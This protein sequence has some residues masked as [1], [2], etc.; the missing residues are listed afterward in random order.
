MPR[1]PE[2]SCR[3]LKL[4]VAGVAFITLLVGC[5]EQQPDPHANT[6]AIPVNDPAY[7]GSAVCSDCHAAEYAAWSDSHH[8]LAMQIATRETVLGNFEDTTYESHGVTSAFSSDGEQF[9]VRTDG[10]D[11]ELKDYT[12]THTFGI[13]PLQQYLVE[14]P[15]GHY[16]MLPLAWDTRLREEGGQRWFHLYPGEDIDY[17]D[18]LHWTGR[19]QNWNYMCAECHSTNLRK[20]YDVAT[21]S[22]QTTWS[23]I[24]VSCEACHGPASNHIKWTQDQDLSYKHSGL[25]V[26][27]GREMNWVFSN[28]LDTATRETS[29]AETSEIETCARCHSRRRTIDEDYDHGEILMQSHVPALLTDTLYFPDGQIKDEVYVYGSF[30][31]SLMYHAGV[32]CSDCHEPHSLTLR[33]P[34]NELCGQCHKADA[35]DTP[36]HHY[37]SFESEGSQCVSCHM[38]QRTYMV[39]DPR[40]DH[41]IRI[42]RP[43]LTVKLSLPNACNACHTDKSPKWAADAIAERAPAGYKPGDHFGETL[44]ADRQGIRGADRELARLAADGSTPAIVHATALQRLGA[45]DSVAAYEAIRAGLRDDH[46][47]VRQAALSALSTYEADVRLLLA[48][49]L[50]E[51]PVF[52][53]RIAAIELLADVPREQ[54]N[55]E[56]LERFDSVA[57]EYVASNLAN[58]ERPESHLN[59]GLFYVRQ[60]QFE[61]AL[62]EYEIALRLEPDFIPALVNIADLMRATGRDSE[63]GA[64][65]ERAMSVDP[66]NANIQQAKG[67]WLVRQ[68]RTAEALDYLRRSAELDP[69]QPYFAYLYAVALNSSGAP[70]SAIKVLEDAYR[71]HPGHRQILV[72]LTTIYRDQGNLSAAIHYAE[73]LVA[74][75]PSE[76]NAQR[77]LAELQTVSSE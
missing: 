25:P 8:D 64:Y 16:Q 31:Q 17:A 34:G 38:P 5:S 77:L 47:L 24:D 21:D 76:P 10:P 13:Q 1:I 7:V 28:Y 19:N 49:P 66:E 4:T 54:M 58:A 23:E 35:F 63:G 11:G 30:T 68:G 40:R 57:L 61:E 70:N 42:P 37:H 6:L 56:R 65:L 15:D 71:L 72:A 14:F 33:A 2:F 74:L 67:L 9:A 75:Q 22:F 73:R 46:P 60:R 3:L 20:N 12:I 55:S 39:I 44:W 50:L 18:E 27:L 62:A 36:A 48:P 43:D 29:A 45:Y 26:G 52:G 69:D 53:V 32:T 51:D 59:I 41:S